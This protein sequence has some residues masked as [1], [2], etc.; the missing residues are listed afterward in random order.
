MELDFFN[1]LA[2]FFGEV[3]YERYGNVK[4]ALFTNEKTDMVRL[5]AYNSI[6][7]KIDSLRTYQQDERIIFEEAYDLADLKD[8]GNLA[9]QV[10]LQDIKADIINQLH[11]PITQ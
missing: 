11:I 3:I 6:S 1:N 10:K 4:I 7:L 8:M 2:N 5:V 9:W